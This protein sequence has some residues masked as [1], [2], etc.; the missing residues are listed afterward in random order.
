MRPRARRTAGTRHGRPV[1]WRSGPSYQPARALSPS[2]YDS[3]N[4]PAAG[5]P[6]HV[7]SDRPGVLSHRSATWGPA[8]VARGGWPSARPSGLH[9]TVPVGPAS[10]PLPLRDVSTTNAAP[11]SSVETYVP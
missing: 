11:P 6:L 4:L 9:H 7:P 3:Q 5:P 8:P 2:R 10:G 1:R